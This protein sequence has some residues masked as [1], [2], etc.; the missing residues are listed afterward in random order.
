MVNNVEIQGRH[1]DTDLK[2]GH[3]EQCG[4]SEELKGKTSAAGSDG[5]P[6]TEDVFGDTRTSSGKLPREKS[7]SSKV[8]S[9]QRTTASPGEHWPPYE[10]NQSQQHV[11]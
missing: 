10:D 1:E 4:S 6:A 3:Q 8:E 5:V 11:G 2:V 9:A 7:G